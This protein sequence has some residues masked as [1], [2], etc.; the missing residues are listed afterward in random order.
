MSIDLDVL[1]TP[2]PQ[3]S[4]KWLPNHRMVESSKAVQPWREA[5]VSEALRSGHAGSRLTGP[6]LLHVT[7]YLPRPK[8]HHGAR[9]LLPSAPALP[10]RKPDA[11]KLLRST[12]DALTQAGL[13]ADDAQIT[14]IRAAKRYAD[15]RPPGARITLEEDA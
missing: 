4:K 2:A 14:T 10:H 9:G 12:M 6:V 3:G 8:S 15:H 13:I 1:G 11:D 5:I 7:F